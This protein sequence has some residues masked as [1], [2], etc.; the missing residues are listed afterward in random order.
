MEGKPPWY[1]P[2]PQLYKLCTLGKPITKIRTRTSSSEFSFSHAVIVAIII[3]VI[4]NFIVVLI[5]IF[6][7][8]II[9]IAIFIFMVIVSKIVIIIL[10]IVFIAA[11]LEWSLLQFNFHV[12][13]CWCSQE[14]GTIRAIPK[15]R[16]SLGAFVRSLKTVLRLCLFFLN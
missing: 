13:K 11:A 3:I 16:H 2:S 7:I 8:F 5:I 9:V 14:I 4:V 6:V 1:L 10:T 12:L 15:R